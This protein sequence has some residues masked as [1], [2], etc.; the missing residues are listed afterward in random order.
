MNKINKTIS[1][2]ICKGNNITYKLED[3]YSIKETESVSTTN[4]TRTYNCYCENCKNHYQVKHGKAMLK[5]YKPFVEETCF[6][7]VK[8][9][10]SYESDFDRAYKIVSVNDVY[11]ILVEDDMYPIVINSNKQRNLINEHKKVK[12]LVLNTWMNR[13]R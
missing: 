10:V 3:N 4:I 9:Y 12:S 7:D 13:Y 1:C 2:P 11:M 5:R 8:L 6:G